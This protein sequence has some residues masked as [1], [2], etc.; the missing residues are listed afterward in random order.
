MTP[1]QKCNRI[2]RR[3]LDLLQQRRHGHAHLLFGST[4]I[5]CWIGC[6]IAWASLQVPAPR[7]MTAIKDQRLPSTVWHASSALL[8]IWLACLEHLSS[9]RRAPEL[10]ALD[11]GRSFMH[12]YWSVNPFNNLRCV[13]E[14]HGRPVR[15]GWLDQ[16]VQPLMFLDYWIAVP[17]FLYFSSYD[18]LFPCDCIANN[19]DAIS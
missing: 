1:R 14:R 12:P 7:F 5:R 3:R 10:P 16:Y 9:G 18:R 4:G 11:I 15:G 8:H 19:S 13:K 6:G 17:F 2:E